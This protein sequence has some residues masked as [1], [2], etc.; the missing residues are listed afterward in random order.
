M[1]SSVRS[2]VTMKSIAGSRSSVSILAPTQMVGS[3]NE[4]SM[5]KTLKSGGRGVEKRKSVGLLSFVSSNKK[6]I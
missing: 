1:K 5:D 3:I 2:N 6:R 4:A